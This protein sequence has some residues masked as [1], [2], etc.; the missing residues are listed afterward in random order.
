MKTKEE[1]E[2]IKVAMRNTMISKLNRFSLCTESVE[3]K[4]M[5]CGDGGKLLL[6]GGGGEGVSPPLR[7]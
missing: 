2:K 4:R 5:S 7:R 1:R 6:R 3:W